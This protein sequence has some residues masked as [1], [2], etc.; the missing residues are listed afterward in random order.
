MNSPE[1]TCDPKRLWSNFSLA[2]ELTL[3]QEQTLQAHLDDCDTC[4]QNMRSQAAE[5]SYWTEASQL[6]ADCDGYQSCRLL[7]ETSNGPITVNSMP[8]HC[9]P[10]ASWRCWLPPMTP[11]CWGG[12]GLTK[13]P[14]LSDP[15]GWES[16]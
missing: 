8:R 13:S 15:V 10:K 2:N 14:A 7:G 4:Q 9:K 16:C 1:Q 12:L 5:E 11:T 3:A 6:F